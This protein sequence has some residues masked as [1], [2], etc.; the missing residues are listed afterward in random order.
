MALHSVHVRQPRRLVVVVKAQIGGQGNRE[1]VIAHAVNG[2]LEA[3]ERFC[4]RQAVRRRRRAAPS[5]FREN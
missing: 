4:R 3:L 2:D 5:G 1:Y